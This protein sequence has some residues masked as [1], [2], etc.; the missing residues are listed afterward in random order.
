M[1]D[2]PDDLTLLLRALDERLRSTE[3]AMARGFETIIELLTESG[4][5]NDR[6]PKPGDNIREELRSLADLVANIQREQ[7]KHGARL[8]DL[9]RRIPRGD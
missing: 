6:T 9:E 7:L 8:D 5:T 3:A 1:S 2:S 4:G